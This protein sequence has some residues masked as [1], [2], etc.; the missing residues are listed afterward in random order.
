LLERG[1]V[2]NQSRGPDTKLRARCGALCTVFHAVVSAVASLWLLFVAGTDSF[3]SGDVGRV[4]SKRQV[5]W[6]GR[7]TK[8]GST[9]ACLVVLGRWAA[10]VLVGSLDGFR[11]AV[12]MASD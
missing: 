12:D 6:R 2:S 10:V 11:V 4:C 5:G 9:S 8:D 3:G 1:I 7:K